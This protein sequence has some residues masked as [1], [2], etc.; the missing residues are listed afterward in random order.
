[1]AVLEGGVST[2]LAGVGAEAASAL[3]ITQKPIPHGAL[4]HYTTTHRFVLVATQ[5]ANSR[6]FTI[7]NTHATN[8]LVLTRL[9]I[10]WMTASAH[11]AFIEDSIDCFKSTGFSVV[12]T[13]NT[14]TP[15]IS[16]KRTTGM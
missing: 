1:M 7:R 11:T 2:S 16:V 3:H 13:T 9:I 12:D 6:L 8:L 10:K 4:G 14:V 15:T 5:A